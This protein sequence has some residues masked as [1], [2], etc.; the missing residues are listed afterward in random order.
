MV[1]L[2][3]NSVEI[4]HAG[5]NCIGVEIHSYLQYEKDATIILSEEELGNTSNVEVL[6]KTRWYNAQSQFM[7]H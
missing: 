5:V 1:M 3:S 6:S 4:D 7:A 2:C